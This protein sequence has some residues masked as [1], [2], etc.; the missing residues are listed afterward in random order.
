MKY[1]HPNFYYYRCRCKPGIVVF[2]DIRPK[3][4][5]AL[6][7]TKLLFPV[8]IGICCIENAGGDTSSPHLPSKR[9]HTK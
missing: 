5:G 1:P 6:T 7:T 3:K 2:V 8:Y 4:K 9:I